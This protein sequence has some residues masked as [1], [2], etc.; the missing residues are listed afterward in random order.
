MAECDYPI[1]ARSR[2]TTRLWAALARKPPRAP[3]PAV[4]CL[5]DTCP[6][7]SRGSAGRRA[8]T[9]GFSPAEQPRRGLH[10]VRHERCLSKFARIP[11]YPP[12]GITPE[13]LRN[14]LQTMINQ[15]N[16]WSSLN[17]PADKPVDI[18]ILTMKRYGGFRPPNL[19]AYYQSCRDAAA[20]NGLLLIDNYPDWV[21]LHNTQPSTWN[22]YVMAAFTPTR[23]VPK[24]SSCRTSSK[25]CSVKCPSPAR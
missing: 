13:M 14:N 15:I 1:P 2:L 24:P 3:T 11:N 19:S 18:V 20:D 21:N 22:S 23:R 25:R 5:L 7:I 12:V 8:R 6:I 9:T 10:R 16:A 4:A 17:K